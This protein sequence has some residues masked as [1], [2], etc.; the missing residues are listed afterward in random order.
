MALSF[1]RVRAAVALVA[2]LAALACFAVIATVAFATG[3][4]G[5]GFANATW[6][7]DPAGSYIGSTFA[8][9]TL[10]D[11]LGY[12]GKY[13]MKVALSAEVGAVIEVMGSPGG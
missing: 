5:D 4:P 12:T 6:L 1:P 7:N 3:V 2:L 11:G 9:Y 8:A 10:P 13:Y